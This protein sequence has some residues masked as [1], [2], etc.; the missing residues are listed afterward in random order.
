MSKAA[1][2]PELQL[3]PIFWSAD[4]EEPKTLKASIYLVYVSAFDKAGERVPLD[5]VPLGGLPEHPHQLG[6][7]YGAP[8]VELV[9]RSET[10]TILARVIHRCNV[11]IPQAAP[12][13]PA[14]AP[15]APMSEALALVTAMNERTDKLMLEF[16]RATTAAHTQVI[17]VIGKMAGQRI[18]DSQSLFETLMKSKHLGPAAAA[19]GADKGELAT[20]LKGIDW[21]QRTMAGAAEGDEED[22]IEGLLKV[23][24]Q[25]FVRAKM[26]GGAPPPQRE[27]PRPRVVPD[28][29]E[30]PT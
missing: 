5:C 20:F 28:P 4:D 2:P 10:G 25:E 26:G 24:A 3:P 27:R 16:N 22:D 7:K 12:A 21:A 13:A 8:R 6:E 14:A 23:A 17:D 29:P 9:G 30:D 19:V 11:Q 15:A 18:V 1:A